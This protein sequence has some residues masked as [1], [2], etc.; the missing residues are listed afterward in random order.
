MKTLFE[1]IQEHINFRQQIWMLA[2]VELGKAYKGSFLGWTWA[3][4]SPAIMIFVYWFAFSVGLRAGGD[5]AGYPYFLWLIAGMIPWFCIRSL[6]SGGASSLRRYT[7]LINKVKFP[8]ST[9]PTFVSIS[10]FMVHII[11][12]GIMLVLFVVFGY[13][14]SI[15]WLQ[16]PL[17][18]ILLFVFFNTWSLFAGILGAFSRDFMNLVKSITLALMWLSGIFYEVNDIPNALIREIMLFNPITV[19][20]NGYRNCL[21]YEKWFWEVPGELCNFGLMYVVMLV[22][23]VWIYKRLRKEIPDV[24]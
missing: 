24:I 17:Y 11:L 4:V 8:I 7:Y 20:V 15:Y 6:F 9:I 12:L 19:I 23:A 22:L 21:I 1:I 2:K 3:I 18:M 10:A 5:V 14:P 16:L 13:M